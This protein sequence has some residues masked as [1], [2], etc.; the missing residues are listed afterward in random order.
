MLY[1][2]RTGIYKSG[3]NI[4]PQRK[5]H[6]SNLGHIFQEKSASYG[7]GNM[8]FSNFTKE[9]TEKNYTFMCEF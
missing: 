3:N 6:R 9:D 4:Y 8:V 1:N 2:R 7:P 5:R